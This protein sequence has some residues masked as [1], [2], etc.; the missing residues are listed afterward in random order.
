MKDFGAIKKILEMEIRKE[1]ALRRLWLSPSGYIR[2]VSE[3][4]SME[5]VKPVSTLLANHFKLSTT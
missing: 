2:K 4:F 3:R 1:K 5:N